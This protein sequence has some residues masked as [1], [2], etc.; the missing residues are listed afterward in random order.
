VQLTAWLATLATRWSQEMSW[1][2]AWLNTFEVR[3][4]LDWNN[5]VPNDF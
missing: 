3:W 4:L 1:K 5:N 2:F